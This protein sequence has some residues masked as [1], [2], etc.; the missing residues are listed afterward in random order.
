MSCI[1]RILININIQTV[2]MLFAKKKLFWNLDNKLSLWIFVPFRL[3]IISSSSWK[4]LEALRRAFFV[5]R[6]AKKSMNYS[7][8]GFH[9]SIHKLI[10]FIRT[11]ILRKLR[12]INDHFNFRSNR[13][14]CWYGISSMARF[15]FQSIFIDFRPSLSERFLAFR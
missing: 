3:K 8:R 6:I 12:D 13:I 7:R 5:I 9:T 14:H 10:L 15:H 2:W 4:I 1:L 11:F